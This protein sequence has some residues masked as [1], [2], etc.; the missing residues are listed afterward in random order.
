ML[1]LLR[2]LLSQLFCSSCLM[3]LVNTITSHDPNSLDKH[4][5]F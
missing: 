4:S 3:H 1:L 5:Q 2:L